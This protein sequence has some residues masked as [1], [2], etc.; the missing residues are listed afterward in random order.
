MAEALCKLC[1]KLAELRRSHILP[2]FLFKPLYDEVHRYHVLNSRPD[3][4]AKFAQKGISEQLLC[5]SCEGAISKYEAYAASVMGGDEGIR[6]NWNNGAIEVS[7]L[8][9]HRFKLFLIS[10]LWRAS[11]SNLDFFKMVQLGPHAE[12][13]RLMLLAGEAGE[14]D[15]YGCMIFP[16][17]HGED[18]LPDLMVS[19]E[20]IKI[21]GRWWQRFIF[22]GAAWVFY[23][24]SRP[25][26]DFTQ[27][28][29]LNRSGFLRAVPYDLKG[30][31]FA[32]ELA[33]AFA[34]KIKL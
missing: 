21:G 8:E 27:G 29:L 1:G 24:D 34:G 23:C 12:K 22:S 7:G 17:R 19:P 14:P 10:I 16:V 30:T 15:R 26:P 5:D 11:V 32:Q 2:E 33:D 3:I 18:Q 13:L 28:L 6:L 25:A 4:K 9:Y 31:N 20:P